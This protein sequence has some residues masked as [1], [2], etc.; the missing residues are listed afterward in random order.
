MPTSGMF[1]VFAEPSA[2]AFSFR[3]HRSPPSLPSSFHPVPLFT[4]FLAFF[5]FDLKINLYLKAVRTG[6]AAV[7]V[8]GTDTIVL[9]VKKKSTAS[10]RTPDTIFVADLGENLGFYME[11]NVYISHVLSN[12]NHKQNLCCLNCVFDCLI[13]LPIVVRQQ[14]D[15]SKQYE[16]P[17][18]DEIGGLVVGDIGLFDSNRDIVIELK[19]GELKRI[20]KLNPK[21][22]SLQYPILFPYGEDGYRP[23]LKWSNDYKGHDPKR[24]R[25]PMRAFIAYQI[26]ER[27]PLLDTL[28]KGGRLFQQFLVDSYATLEEDRLDYIRKNQTNLRSEIYKGIYDAISKGDSDANNVGQKVILPSSYTGSTRYMLNNYQD[29]MAICRHY[30]NPDLFI[31]FTCNV[32]W[33]EIVRE[34]DNK[35]G[36]KGED[37]PDL[38]SRV[39]KMK[40]DDMINYIKSGK[41]FGEVEAEICTI[42][43][44]KRGLPHCH[45]LVWLKEGYKCFSAVDIDSIICAELPDKDVDPMLYDVVNQFM[46]HGPCGEINR[47][48]PCMRGG[49]DRARVVFQDKPED[50]ILAYLNCRYI[51][52]YEAVWRLFQYPIHSRE[53]A[54][55]RLSIHLPL[56][57]NV[58]FNGDQSLES[59]VSQKGIEDTMLTSWFKA[60]QMFPEART[61][62]YTEFPTKFVWD[63]RN[64]IWKPRKRRRSIGRIA[65]VHPT[66]GELYYLRMLLNLQKGALNFDHIKTIDGIIHPSYQAA[67]KCLGLLGDDKE[68]IEALANAVDT[69]SCSQLRQ[70]KLF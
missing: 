23:D 58:V 55:E 18:C 31:T 68:W 7:G 54:V 50:E 62:T 41:V 37:R 26:Q 40:L 20:T 12:H 11:H 38:I 42:E 13:A 45:M 34:L 53:P 21:F 2:Q 35:P 14:A 9:G 19:A 61:L 57:Q 67:C 1:D 36:Y 28:L 30:G 46:I 51:S 15:D 64:K 6:N 27:G 5:S 16:Q 47:N 48:S 22:M 33:P 17:T 69:A 66:S 32:K 63:S 3:F 4:C 65:Y 49:S 10:S 70:L 25:V 43:F 24:G 44:Q 29:A 56:E 39:F 60:N 52:P 59:I 8:R